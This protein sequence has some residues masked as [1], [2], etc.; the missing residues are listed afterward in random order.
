MTLETAGDDV[1]EGIKMCFSMFADSENLGTA[2]VERELRT[3]TGDSERLLLTPVGENLF[4]VEESSFVTDAVYRDIIR[5][6]ETQD[7]A[8][9][10]VEITERSPLVTNSW[11]LSQELIQSDAV[12][13]VLKQVMD[14]GGNWEQ[15]FGGGLIVH[16]SPTTAKE[17]EEQILRIANQKKSDAL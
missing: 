2:A 8:L 14:Q 5:A 17:I 1:L 7:S 3:A 9:L 4:R 10:F 11:I 6:T 16:T 13:S 15:V 12:Q